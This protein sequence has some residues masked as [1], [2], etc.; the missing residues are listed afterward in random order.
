H[1]KNGV[2]KS[3][4]A[5]LLEI[6]SG[7]YTFEN[8]IRFQKLANII[9]SCEIDFNYDGNLLYKVILKPHLWKFDDNLNRVNPL[10]LGNFFKGEQ[11]IK[12]DF[13]K[14]RKNFYIKTI[15]GNESL[16][17]QIYFFKDIFVAKINQKL[18]KLENAI[19]YL[20]KYQESL[21]KNKIVEII[22]N[23]CQLQEN[24][25]EQLNRISNFTSSII[26]RKSS[27]ET[28]EKRLDLLKK[29]EFI[30]KNDI[31]SL[32]KKKENE[33]NRVKKT[34]DEL[35]S[36]YKELPNIEQKLDELQNKFDVKTKKLIKKLTKLR[37]QK[38][39]L[40]EQLNSQFKFNLETL[41]DVKSN[42]KT[43]EIKDNINHYQEK[44]TKYK[45]NIE[46][47]NKENERIIEI[48]KFLTQLRDIC[49]KASSY[50]FGKEKII[51]VTNDD[52]GDLTFSFAE[53]FEIFHKNNI[54]FKQNEVLKEY[55]NEVLDFNKKINK[56]K[57]KFNI[58]TEYNKTIEEITKLENKLKG[59]GSKLD[60]FIDLDIRLDNLKQKYQER[61]TIIENLEKE[62]L[63]Y[64]RNVE[65]LTKIIDDVKENPS[66][67]SLIIDLNKIGIKI[68]QNESNVEE[69]KKRISKIE[70]DINQRQ[71]ELTRL[72]LDKEET[73][74]GLEKIKEGIDPISQEIKNAAKQFGYTQVGKFIDYFKSHNDK[75][76][77]YL[78]NTNKLHARL[79]ILKD[80]MIKVL[81]GEKPKNQKDI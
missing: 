23:Y 7:N 77:K 59:K 73:E 49:S 79:R 47:L 44:I 43:K 2:G 18:K 57:K 40:K 75:F 10:T 39:Q 22:E 33:K 54:N 46:K 74:K 78:E 70:Q 28:L 30:S 24:F 13:K 4:A 80:D 11:K 9:E 56:N 41:D 65:H 35:K 27:L 68:D 14:F 16:E 81:E 32:Q 15:R 36:N 53:L 62:I 38:E 71:K 34:K 45:E 69:C 66:Q 42:K 20:E 51:N 72:E 6:T 8:K 1:G 58:L 19:K 3:M 31:E 63:G 60:N 29:L 21:N 12:I 37:K 50:N 26:N 25:N 61:K 67:T 64:N 55:K 17:Q 52:Q 5:T 48:N 76:K